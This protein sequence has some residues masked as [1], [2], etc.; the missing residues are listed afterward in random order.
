LV[1]ET[2]QEYQNLVDN[3]HNKDVVITVVHDDYRKHAAESSI[4]AA[5]LQYDDNIIDIV[6]NHSESLGEGLD[7]SLL[8]SAKRFWVY[9]VKEFYHLTGFT[10]AYDISLLCHLNKIK[11]EEITKPYVFEH[12]YELNH[13]KFS[14][15]RVVPLVK[16]L[17][18]SRN[19]L[20]EITKHKLPI[21]RGFIKYNQAL[22]TLAKLEKPGL[23][24]QSGRFNTIF[25]NG[26]GYSKYNMLTTTGRPSNTFRGINFGALNKND[27][28][29]DQI[30]TRFEK[31]MLVEF[32]YDAFH[33]RLLAKLLKYEIPIDVSLHQYFADNIYN[34]S[35]EDAKKISWQILYGDVKVDKN[36]NPFFYKVDEMTNSLWHHFKTHKQFKT[37]IY[38]RKFVSSVILE[39]N[40]NK[41]LNYFIQSYETEQNIETIKKVQKYLGFRSTDM[42][43]YT[44]DSFLFDLDRT[45]GLRTVLELKEILQGNSFP[46]KVKAGL[47]Y[48]SMQDITERING[49][50]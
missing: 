33:L 7:I 41:V 6:F 49:Y 35:Y 18:Y 10:N 45:E 24:L 21:D 8:S 9:D 15:N 32:D 42:I 22:I 4:I 17:E 37:H 39:A 48:G 38:R 20:S 11:L 50:K 47:N 12:I 46:V 29:R 43:L 31:G 40:K 23:R 28:T 36:E 19:K 1:I 27:G 5:T 25:K 34:S 26:Y 30:T 2:L 13:N 44:Y 14:M 16:I 3:I